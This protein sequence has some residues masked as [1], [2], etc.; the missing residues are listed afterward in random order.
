MGSTK[1][2]WKVMSLDEFLYYNCPECD[3]K[4]QDYTEFFNHAVLMHELAQETLGSNEVKLEPDPYEL[5][6]GEDFEFPMDPS[7]IKKGE[8][9]YYDE[10]FETIEAF[11]QHETEELKK[12][13]KNIETLVETNEPVNK[14]VCDYCNESFTNRTKLTSHMIAVHETDHRQYQ[15][16]HCGKKF[17]AKQHYETHILKKHEEACFTCEKCGSKFYS[18]KSLEKHQ[19]TVYCSVDHEKHVCDHCKK[20]FSTESKLKMHKLNAKGACLPPDEQDWKCK[21]CHIQLNSLKAY[22]DHQWKKHQSPR[23]Y[24]DLCGNMVLEERFEVHRESCL[25]NFNENFAGHPFQCDKC[26]RSY[27]TKKLLWHHGIRV[28]ENLQ[29]KC[30][31][32]D[33]TFANK[34]KLKEHVKVMHSSRVYTCEFCDGTFKTD[35]QYWW[36]MDKVHP[37]KIMRCKYCNRRFVTKERLEKHSC[38]AKKEA[39]AKTRQEKDHFDCKVCTA[40]L[41]TIVELKDHMVIFHQSS[42]IFCEFCGKDIQT[43]KFY[44]HVESCIQIYNEKYVGKKHKCDRCRRS[45]DNYGTMASHIRHNHN[46]IRAECQHCGKS[47][48]NH[49]QRNDHVKVEHEGILFYCEHCGQSFKTTANMK[50]HLAK[51]HGEGKKYHCDKC[52]AVFVQKQRLDEHNCEAVQQW[53][54]ADK[55]RQLNIAEAQLISE[56]QG[57]PSSSFGEHLRKSNQPN[58]HVQFQ[59]EYGDCRKVFNDRS[60]YN[61]HVKRVHLHVTCFEKT[62]EERT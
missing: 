33:L 46:K 22:T 21:I 44:N 8:N 5:N 45:F 43:Q 26:K 48:A 52:P 7:D 60:N 62:H 31:H 24:C 28:H 54:L 17:N 32:C 4:T 1:N 49:S 55:K 15:C 40:K 61:K 25:K 20:G 42:E 58:V 29:I 14:H 47:F 34:T 53:T 6:D 50:Y 51:Y 39:E 59:C 56:M 2:P 12:D 3:E 41:S 18:L 30:D 23:I 10:S 16:E 57:Q 9:D 27:K 13:T 36:H 19:R 11:T 35:R 37:E 38:D